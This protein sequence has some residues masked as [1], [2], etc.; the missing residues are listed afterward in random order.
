MIVP[1]FFKVFHNY[2]RRKPI[3]LRED[4][5]GTA[6]LSCQWVKQDAERI[7]IGVDLD[8]E[9]LDWGIQNNL[10]NI[11]PAS[12]RVKLICDDVLEVNTDKVDIINASNYSFCLLKQRP[13]LKKYF[14]KVRESLVND[15]IFVFDIYGGIDAS[16]TTS[17]KRNCGDFTYKWEQ[18]KFNPITREALN[19]ISF[20]FKDGSWIKN[21]FSYDFRLYTLPELRDLLE[22]VG[23]KESR[24]W[25]AEYDKENE[26]NTSE[27]NEIYD[28][29]ECP[30]WNA[31][32][33]ALV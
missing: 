12:E 13:I 3:S 16:N 24:V 32:I 27:Y 25:W 14:N 26:E 10:I 11:G 19:C 4:F 9:T 6:Y 5:C 20:G 28:I 18:K 15:G 30:A 7:A 21:A 2:R 31:W 29:E 33:V 17:R 1:F 22:E 23:F 8:K